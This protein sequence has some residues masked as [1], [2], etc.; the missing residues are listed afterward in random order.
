MEIAW[1]KIERVWP[2]WMEI[3]NLIDIS[4]A[5]WYEREDFTLD[6]ECN[7]EITNRREADERRETGL[8][9]LDESV[10]IAENITQ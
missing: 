10:W 3:E 5:E 1:V 7:E 8:I 4:N 6:H 2:Y 9:I